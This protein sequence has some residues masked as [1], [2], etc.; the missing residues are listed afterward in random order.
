MNLQN[1]YVSFRE[2]RDTALSNQRRFGKKQKILLGMYLTSFLIFLYMATWMH[3]HFGAIIY[4]FVIAPIGC[5]YAVK[6]C[7]EFEFPVPESEQW[8]HDL[9]SYLL[10][11]GVEISTLE[12]A[13][14]PGRIYWNPGIRQLD[15]D[16]IYQGK[17]TIHGKPNIFLKIYDK[18]GKLSFYCDKAKLISAGNGKMQWKLY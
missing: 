4:F 16:I 2:K 18:N 3:S 7:G 14:I 9:E 13:Y 6:F 11:S 17:V 1:S 8:V 5:W 12:P 10:E 15:F